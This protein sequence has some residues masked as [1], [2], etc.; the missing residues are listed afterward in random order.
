MAERGERPWE[1]ADY[2][3]GM[4]NSPCKF[5]LLFYSK[6]AGAQECR[7]Y[8]SEARDDEAGRIAI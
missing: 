4:G 7:Q 5:G 3:G 6:A 2:E 8:E 1:E